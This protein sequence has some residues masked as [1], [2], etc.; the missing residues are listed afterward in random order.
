MKKSDFIQAIAE[1][2]N[3]PMLNKLAR[4]N[5]RAVVGQCRHD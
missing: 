3:V 5:N 4:A 1:V 2:P